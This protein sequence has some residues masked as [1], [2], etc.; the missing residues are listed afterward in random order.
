MNKV[1]IILTVVIIL[2]FSAYA[3]TIYIPGD[4]PT[5]QA[6]I[7]AAFDGDTVLVADGTYTG[8]GNKNID[9]IGKVIVVIS[10][11]GPDST[12]IDCEADG[13]GFY[14]HSD[15]DTNSV[16]CGFTV[17]NG[18]AENGGGIYCNSSSPEISNCIIVSD[19]AFNCSHGGGI[20]CHHASPLI[21]N[22][23]ISQNSTTGTWY[24]QLGGGIYCGE[25]SNPIIYNCTINENHAGK[26]GGICI[27]F[28]ACPIIDQCT[29]NGNSASD[30]GGISCASYNT[31]IT[32]SN[33]TINGNSAYGGGGIYCGQDNL[34]IYNCT[35]NGNTAYHGGGIHCDWYTD[36]IISHCTISEN[37]ATD[38]GGGGILCDKSIATI[39][40]CTISR[41]S[42]SGNGGGVYGLWYES[43][44]SFSY[45]LIYGNS[46]NGQGGGIFCSEAAFIRNCTI[47]ENS[48]GAE[49]G[50]ILYG[51]YF[52]SPILEIENSIVAGN[53]GIGGVF[54]CSSDSVDISYGDFYNN[55]GGDFTGNPPPGLGTL[56]TVNANGDSCDVFFNIFEDPL[57]ASP[58]NGNFQITWANFPVPDSTKSPCIDAGDP[59]SPLDPDSTIADMGALYFDQSMLL[60]ITLTPYNPPII[61]PQGGDAFAF[62]IELANCGGAPETFDVWV[63]IGVPGGFQFTVLGPVYDLTLAAGSSIE[64]DRTVFVPGS[65]P[66]G[67]YACMGMIGEYPWN[68]VNSDAFPFIKEGADGIWKGSEG[69]ICSGEPFPDE[70]ITAVEASP[71]EFALHGSFPNPFNPATIISFE[72]RDAGFVELVVYDIQG[73]EVAKL[74]DGWTSAGVYQMTF[75]ASTLSSGI[76][77]ARMMAGD[78][79]QT[80]KIML[81]K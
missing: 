14:F 31:Y 68:V 32:I 62:N 73:R 20:Y 70:I 66:A 19:T 2:S 80:Q 49:G 10:E 53:T 75:D 40:Y 57:F 15:E 59:E 36:P 4:Y 3:I 42:T 54:F 18:Y 72:L 45:C 27:W 16:L 6:G 28:N 55:E 74:I 81:I 47:V 17:T 39:E 60:T 21:L 7:D 51:G 5:I 35:I 9:F 63:N 46:A 41:N 37:T 78:F 8:D 29:I 76:Y 50:G 1:F 26:G 65:A 56:I 11:N 71:G 33:C 69:W 61:I 64:R 79:Q 58:W 30:G 52:I 43:R 38:W 44:P 23:I 48:A 25:S 12:I 24:G 34:T 22:C 67:E 13:R 77:F